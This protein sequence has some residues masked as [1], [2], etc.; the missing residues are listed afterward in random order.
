MLVAAL[1]LPSSLVVRGELALPLPLLCNHWSTVATC[2]S[3]TGL[4]WL[5]LP[6]KFP[7]LCHGQR[8]WPCV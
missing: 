4:Q 5:E 7:G 8:K 6:R 2:D 1:S 3:K